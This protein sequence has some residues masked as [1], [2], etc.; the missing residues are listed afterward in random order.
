MQALLRALTRLQANELQVCVYAGQQQHQTLED[1][2]TKLRR[3][4]CEVRV[5]FSPSLVTLAVAKTQLPRQ[6]EKWNSAPKVA[7]PSEFSRV[8]RTGAKVLRPDDYLAGR[9]DDSRA[10]LDYL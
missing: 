4:A 1:G 6:S 9:T 7:P 5:P 8:L 3:R 2:E 10:T